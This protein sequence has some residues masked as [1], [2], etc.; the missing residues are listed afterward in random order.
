MRRSLLAVLIAAC[1]APLLVAD[2]AHAQYFGRNKVQY[3]AFDFQIIR[4][5]HFDVYYYP[6]EREAALDAAR[7]VERSY[8]RLSRVLQHEFDE[9][10]PLIIYASHTDFQQTNALPW[11][12][13]EST[14][15]VTES[16]KSRM[17]LPFTGS[18]ADFDH[19]LTHELVHG[20][21]YDVIFRR[22]VVNEASPFTARLPLWFMEGMAEYLS[23][24][25]IDAHTVSWLRDAV[26]KG[27]LRSIAEMSQRD[28]YLS[29][30]F[31]QSLWAFIGSKW[32]DEVVGILLQKAPRIGIERAFTSTLGLSLDELNQEWQAEVR[33]TYLAQVTEYDQPDEFAE[34]L[35]KHDK[36]YDPWYL[37]PA[38]S[39][40]GND[41][42]YL[43]QHDGF[44][45]DLWLADARTGKVK[46]R[47]VGS[48]RDAG[49]ES[50]RYMNSGASFSHDGRYI[51]FAAKDG[52]QDAL[53]VYDMQ[54]NRMSR[55]MKFDLNG[56]S[57]P[58]WAP[59]GSRI[60]F[61]GLD[62]GIS[63]LFVTDLDG[64]L[65]R[66][67]NDRYADLL[68]AWSPDGSRIA[69][70]T[71]RSGTDLDLLVYGN[72]RI[73]VMD[74]ATHRID[75]LPQQEEGKNI[76]PA[77]SPD[78]T[79]LIWV[80]DRDGTNNL[81]LYD[82][83]QGELSQ[84]TDVLS[85]VIA[86]TPLSPVIS[87]SRS[88]R[89]LFTYFHNAGYD[90]Y[91][92]DDPLALPR[93][94][95]L[96]SL[97][98]SRAG[99]EPAAADPATAV[100]A[101]RAADSAAVLPGAASDS[102]LAAPADSTPTPA[103]PANGVAD[104]TALPVTAAAD[105]AVAAPPLGARP[106]QATLSDSAGTAVLAGGKP[107]QTPVAQRPGFVSS[108]YRDPDGEFRRSALELPGDPNAPAP[109]S[110][111]ALLDSAALALPDT[112]VFELRDYKVKLTPDVIGRPSIG[113]E[114]GGYYGNGVYG[115]SYISLSDMLGNHNLMV[116]G[117]IN[118]SLSDASFFSAYTFL[119]RRMN[120]SAALWQVP[121][122]RYVGGGYFPL[123][124]GGE[125]REV[126]ANIFL[127]DVI[128]GGQV[129][130]SYPFSTF[131]RVE[132]N[133]TGV[134]YQSDILYRG[135]DTRTFKPI[136]IDQSSAGFS[137]AQPEVAMVFDNSLFGWTG[138]VV[139]RRY[140]IQ[141]S[142]TFGDIRFNEALVDFR[143]YANW[144]QK[145]VFATRFVGLSRFGGEAERFGLYW[146]SP[147]YIRGYD[148]NSFKPSSGECE[149]SRHWGERTS[150]SRCPV[151]DQLVGA[152]AAFVNAEVR[153]PI[154]TELQIGFLGS[155][156]PVDAVAFFDG[157]MAWDGRVCAITD[158]SRADNC[159]AGASHDVSI[160]W[161]RKAGE[162][163]FLVREPLFS[164]GLGLR[165]NVFYTVL[166]LDYAWPVNRA[167][168]SGML[169]F[170]FGP[171]F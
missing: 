145:V 11:F 20:F 58:S 168:R 169:S 31:G 129:G 134:N 124:I 159:A 16:L 104:S 19:V 40:D 17:I 18:Y 95:V 155:F 75:V 78:G 153:F 143:N 13:D 92:V 116:S 34:R 113:A 52:G 43:S 25:R 114:V 167:D 45:F 96:P 112:S 171:S 50:L 94:R 79:K 135:Y 111:I 166:R 90:T 39:P 44:A 4:T 97:V 121:L 130:L 62:G 148:Y 138:P 14:G 5:E 77:W 117:S 28:D 48:A 64:N 72:T 85:G 149:D 154:I 67:T 157:G 82:L 49:L 47:L 89:M 170:S 83:Q 87:W 119:K 108:Y 109:V 21:Q 74:A 146:G 86:V 8:A 66:L 105:T 122:Y 151:R 55:K 123:D 33:T 152:S 106:P 147:Y 9:R 56:I 30:R 32:G 101:N 84:I 37:A 141:L 23:I 38:I 70:T 150:L 22:G 103:V 120:L 140:R 102:T 128:R 165:I 12:L 15:G 7:M 139:G 107:L 118:G 42:V 142:R 93:R 36:L 115:G 35:T 27:Y 158:Y 137:Y 161:D 162:D 54:R 144:K 71:D 91:A 131:R 1:C 60:V 110:V 164:Y 76:N 68:P 133:M 59:D 160:T 69:F 127:R 41:F 156:P 81:Y 126:A 57:A 3:R 26:L 136:E 6:Q 80:S 61:T 10:K 99:S 65:T 2:S 73:A 100:P 51:A 125:Q 132:L 63:D 53:Y 88:G 24:G 29:Y 46:K 98:A 163:P